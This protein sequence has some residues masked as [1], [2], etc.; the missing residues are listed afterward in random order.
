MVNGGTRFRTIEAKGGGCGTRLEERYHQLMVR[1]MS[2]YTAYDI[3]EKISM[4]FSLILIPWTRP[5]V[6]HSLILFQFYISDKNP[7]KVDFD[8]FWEK[9]NFWN[10]VQWQSLISSPWAFDGK[11]V[12]GRGV[13]L[14]CNK[15]DLA[16]KAFWPLRHNCA[17]EN[18]L[19][20]VHM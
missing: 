10:P 3:C 14:L 4:Y 20:E 15:R 19:L 13:S 6:H 2:N 7:M 18:R 1:W 16:Y 5:C 8:L 17:T 12:H 11:P 9:W